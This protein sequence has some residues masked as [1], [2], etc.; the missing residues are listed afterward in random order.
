VGL[1]S[2]AL[3]FTAV[4]AVIGWRAWRAAWET[5]QDQS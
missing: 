5:L 4:F 1:A 3:P 2:F